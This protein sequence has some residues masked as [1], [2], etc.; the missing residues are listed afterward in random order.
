MCRNRITVALSFTKLT[1]ILQSEIEMAVMANA[2]GKYDYGGIECGKEDMQRLG[3]P[4]TWEGKQEIAQMGV[5]DAD[6][7]HISDYGAWGARRWRI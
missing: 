5:G 1:E 7:A 2:N 3:L 6:S 4:E